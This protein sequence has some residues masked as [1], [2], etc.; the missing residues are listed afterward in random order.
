M[1]VRNPRDQANKYEIEVYY[2]V[3]CINQY[4]ESVLTSGM[5]C[6]VGATS[7]ARAIDTDKYTRKIQT[8]LRCIPNTSR[9]LSQSVMSAKYIFKPA[10][11]SKSCRNLSGTSRLSLHVNRS[12]GK[13][14]RTLD[15]A[16]IGLSRLG[17]TARSCASATR[18]DHY[19]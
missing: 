15:G 10:K 19:S 8:R 12:P 11:C 7:L 2:I 17:L 16:I 9:G 14:N 5:G 18:L 13:H 3:K 4:R 1:N 6:M